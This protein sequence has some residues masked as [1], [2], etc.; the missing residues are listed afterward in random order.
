[1]LG[2]IERNEVLLDLRTVADADVLAL[3]AAIAK[4]A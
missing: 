3:A 1:V 4:A 2:R